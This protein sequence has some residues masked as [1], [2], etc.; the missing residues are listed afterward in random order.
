VDDSYFTCDSL[1]TYK[2]G[3]CYKVLA[4]ELRMKGCIPKE[5]GIAVI[6]NEDEQATDYISQIN[7]IG[8]TATCKKDVIPFLCLYLFGLCGGY[9]SFIHPTIHTC[10]QVRDVSC[11][12]EWKY[13]LA[14]GAYLP[15]CRYFPEDVSSCNNQGNGSG[16]SNLAG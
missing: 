14:L 7:L 12:E 11:P 5:E 15:E 10:E 6:S 8:V 16:A 1:V 9:N 13:A 3:K 4:N 2:E